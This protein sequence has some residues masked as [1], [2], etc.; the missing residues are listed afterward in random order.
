MHEEKT[1]W[2]AGK[3][4]QEELEEIDACRLCETMPEL[5]QTCYA[6]KYCHRQMKM[7]LDE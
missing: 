5:K 1:V 7:Q 6:A 3:A 4:P 2:H